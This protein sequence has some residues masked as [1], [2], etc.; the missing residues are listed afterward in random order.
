MKAVNNVV[1]PIGT[2]CTTALVTV[3]M[4]SNHCHLQLESRE[5]ELFVKRT[6][7]RQSLKELGKLAGGMHHNAVG[8]AIRF[9]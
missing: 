7:G 1:D 3:L 6:Q 9:L 4:M 2:V 5:A 8:I